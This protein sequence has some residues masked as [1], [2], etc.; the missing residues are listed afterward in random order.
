MGVP[1]S[2][3]VELRCA[4]QVPKPAQVPCRPPGSSGF[5]GSSIVDRLNNA[6]CS[7]IEL[8]ETVENSELG[9]DDW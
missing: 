7:N 6:A 5:S 4:E 8:F 1:S 2:K 9:F 3:L